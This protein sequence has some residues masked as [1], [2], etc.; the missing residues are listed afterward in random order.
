MAAPSEALPAG[1]SWTSPWLA[2]VGANAVGEAV[3]LG[4]VFAC[5]FLFI[6]FWGEPASVPAL[7]ALVGLTILLGLVEGSVVGFCQ[8]WVLREVLPP[9]GRRRW[10]GATS[11]GATVAWLL[12]MIPSTVASFSPDDTAAAPAEPP[13]TLILALAAGMG[14]VGGLVLA[15]P[16]WWVLRR[17]RPRAGLWL[18]ANAVAWAAGMP[19]IF[20]LVGATVGEVQSVASFA[21]FL[22][23]LAVAG[24]IVGVVHGWVLFTRIVPQH[25]EPG[26]QAG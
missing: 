26:A 12:G 6:R 9:I 7:I 14:L 10:M 15:L 19:W 18:P 25:H 8:W 1:R 23:G 11:V 21:L 5:G 2:W 24:A 13:L 4:L 20:W 22:A 17:A 3:G 16:Q